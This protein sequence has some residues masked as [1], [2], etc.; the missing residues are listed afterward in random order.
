MIYQNDQIEDQIFYLVDGD[1]H[2][3][4]M[5]DK[6]LNLTEE[7]EEKQKEEEIKDLIDDHSRNSSSTNFQVNPQNSY[8]FF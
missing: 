7:Q 1:Q 5:W 3:R 6:R 2:L 8:L 4:Q